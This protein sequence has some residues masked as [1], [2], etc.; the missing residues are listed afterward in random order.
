MRKTLLVALL[1]LV[2]MQAQAQYCSGGPSSTLDSQ[3]DLVELTGEMGSAIDTVVPCASVGT[4]LTNLT[5]TDTAIVYRDSSYTL[6]LRAGSCGGSY[7]NRLTV[8]VD[9]NMNQSFE[10]AELVGYINGLAGGASATQTMTITV[11]SGISVGSTRMRVIQQET[12][13]AGPSGPCDTYSWGSMNDYTVTI[14]GPA[15]SCPTPYALTAAGIGAD[16]VDLTWTTTAASTMIAVIPSDSAVST[17]TFASFNGTTANVSGLLSDTEYTAYAY[18]ACGSDTAMVSFR[19]LC[20]VFATPYSEDFDGGAFVAATDANGTNGYLSSCWSTNTYTSWSGTNP[21]WVVGEGTT[22]SGSSL[23]SNYSAGPIGD[24]TSG[25]G[26]YMFVEGGGYS[27][28]GYA[29]LETPLIDLSSLTEPYLTFDAHL[30][31]NY[32]SASYTPKMSIEIS[33]DNGA[34]WTKYQIQEGPFDSQPTKAS[35]YENIGIALSSFVDDTVRIAFLLEDYYFY[36]DLAIDNIEIDEAPSCYAPIVSVD[37]VSYDWVT[38]NSLTYLGTSYYYTTANATAKTTGSLTASPDTVSNL[39]SDSTYTFYFYS[40]CSTTY[41]DTVGPITVT[42]AVFNACATITT[43]PYTEGFEANSPKKGCWT[44]EYVVGTQDWD[45]AATTSAWTSSAPG[46]FEGSMFAEHTESSARPETRLVSPVMDMSAYATAKVGFAYALRQY[47]S[48]YTHRLDLEYRL[49]PS[50]PWTS[51]WYAD[52]NQN[53]SGSS[54]AWLE[55]EVVILS[56]SSTMQFSFYAQDNWGYKIALDSVVFDQ[57]PTCVAPMSLAAYDITS[58]SASVTWMGLTQNYSIDYGVVGSIATV[59]TAA[60]DTTS[61]TGLSASTDY[62][63]VVTADC[64]GGT[65]SDPSDTLFFTTACLPD[66]LGWSEGFENAANPDNLYGPSSSGYDAVPN[67]CW[68]FAGTSTSVYSNYSVIY[69]PT[70][71][72]YQT[73]YPAY[74]G[75]HFLY[76]YA[77]SNQGLW[78][79]TPQLHNLGNGLNQIR[80]QYW[81]FSSTSYGDMYVVAAQDQQGFASSNVIYLDTLDYGTGGANSWEERVVEVPVLPAGYEYIYFGKPGGTYSYLRLDDVVFEAQPTCKPATGAEFANIS[82]NSADLNVFSKAGGG[83]WQVELVEPFLNSSTNALD[84]SQ[85]TGTLSTISNGTGTLSGLGADSTYGVWVRQLCGAGDTSDWRGPYIFKT[86][87][88]ANPTFPYVMEFESDWEAEKGC[89]DTTNTA[90]QSNSAQVYKYQYTY[91]TQSSRNLRFYYYANYAYGEPAQ[92]TTQAMTI[93]TTGASLGF[94]YGSYAFTPSSVSSSFAVM[95]KEQGM[96]K[97]DTIGL[98]EGEDL[99]TSTSSAAGYYNADGAEVQFMVPAAMAGKDVKFKMVY[100]GQSGGP[101]YFNVDSLYLGTPPACPDPTNLAQASATTSS[102]TVEWVSPLGQNKGSRVRWGTTSFLQATGA[103]MIGDTNAVTSPFTITGLAA[104]SAYHVFVQDSC[105]VTDTT[106]WLGPIVIQTDCDALSAPYVEDFQTISHCWDNDQNGSSYPWRLTSTAPYYAPNFID[107]SGNGSYG[108]WLDG[109]Y[110]TSESPIL[111]S[112]AVD[113]SALTDPVVDFFVGNVNNNGNPNTLIVD[114]WDGAAWNDSV[115]VYDTNSPNWERVEIDLSNYTVTGPVRVRFHIEWTGTPYPYYNDMVIDDVRFIERPV[116]FSATDA[117]VTPTGANA[118]SVDWTPG[119]ANASG[120][121]INVTDQNTGMSTD[122]FTN[123]SNTYSLTGLSGGGNYCVKVSEV[124]AT[125]D[126]TAPTA[127]EC[128]TTQ[129]GTVYAPYVQDFAAYNYDF[130]CWSRSTNVVGQGTSTLW[131]GTYGD[132]MVGGVENVWGNPSSGTYPSTAYNY[133]IGVDGSAPFGAA[134][135]VESP[136]IDVSA[137]FK[138]QLKFHTISGQAGDTVITWLGD[139]ISN[140]QNTLVVDLWDGAA[141][142]DSVYVNNSDTVAWDSVLIE[143]NQYNVTG[144]VQ[145]R[146]TVNKTA[147]IPAFDDILVDNF[148]IEDDP[149]ILT[150]S[151]IDSAYAFDMNCGDAMIAWGTVDTSGV[152]TMGSADTNRIGT[153]V[154]VGTDSLDMMAGMKYFT[155]GAT[156]FVDGLTPG[157]DYFFWAMDSCI[158]GNTTSVIGPFQFTTDTVPMPTVPSITSVNDTVTTTSDWTLTLSGDSTQVYTWD[159][160]GMTYTGMV[161]NPS[162]TSNDTVDVTL[163]IANDCGSMDT[164]FQIVVTQIG[165]EENILADAK[166][167][168]NPSNGNFNVD[169]SSIEGLDYSIQIMDAMGRVISTKE[170]VT[171]MNNTVRIDAN[172]PSGVYIVKTIVGSETMVDRVSIRN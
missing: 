115:V 67:S 143:L 30:W 95:A 56:T 36:N 28:G 139:T 132:W 122:Y 51:V 48:T 167:Y 86:D 35:A 29:R 83:N 15:S 88:N 96:A 81:N 64:G 18:D 108:V 23:T 82:N 164:T 58:N 75:S 43:F 163:T 87:C 161:A 97:W 8:Y 60:N 78:V 158:S 57:G 120:W 20:S 170:G 49:S 19:T 153:V 113:M 84:F 148:A 123:S 125:G 77:T 110:Y 140:G 52:H 166:I 45:L 89:W 121:I 151:D 61:L 27:Y 160:N 119:T 118:A 66:S 114:L 156:A 124:C 73:N 68:A 50:D 128:F 154:Y 34:T 142:N 85:G 17:A 47:S 162:F 109:S 7:T 80:F 79:M 2:G 1:A 90:Y 137:L 165:Q 107:H 62:F 22:P 54:K 31:Q 72:Y 93:P 135:V 33:N 91:Y 44:N 100:F 59:S 98:I 104:D 131:T 157:T 133:A 53:N 129:C 41:S 42:P 55:E 102:V 141:W 92:A 138:P 159:I 117:V 71:S 5:A 14:A 76:G 6:S 21:A 130:N 127:S 13:S 38:F 171:A 155:T 37:S 74:G 25:Y 136:M 46:P 134:P 101:T 150:C 10:A 94:K 24:A 111:T 70:S 26:N 168:P 9:W 144:P 63:V 32:Q 65:Y 169:F 11:P 112:Q 69:T 105:S 146:F 103:G 40:D 172:L 12:S 39:T 3:I 145:V 152:F 4:G 16:E 126:T 116:C 147:V 99:V 149:A 106:I